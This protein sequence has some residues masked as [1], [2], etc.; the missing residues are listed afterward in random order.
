M[1]YV[2]F[3]HIFFCLRTMWQGEG[4]VITS[5]EGRGGGVLGV[6]NHGHSTCV[7]K[8]LTLC[9][10]SLHIL[11]MTKKSEITI[12]NVKNVFVCL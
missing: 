2:D 6:P 8:I 9:M 1:I 11:F 7:S 10:Y 4:H 3:K 5:G 12:H